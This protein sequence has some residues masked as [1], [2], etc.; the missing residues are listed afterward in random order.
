MVGLVIVSHS[1]KI[2]DGIKDL[3]S[4]L[5]PDHKRIIAAG[6]M[7]DGE[8]GTDAIKIM[9]AIKT[10]D[11]GDGVVILA[12]IGSG[13]MSAEMAIELL[14]EEAETIDAR[15][16]DAPI[17]EGTVAAVVTAS[18]GRPIEE[19]MAAAEETWSTRKIVR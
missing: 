3:A 11:E 19:V 6:G 5:S 10:A 13:I 12:D 8:L 2:A 14:E 1:A 9:D 7:D 16:A 18:L 4:E 17:V 15:I